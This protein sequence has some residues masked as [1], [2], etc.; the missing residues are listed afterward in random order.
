MKADQKA[1]VNFPAIKS[2]GQLQKTGPEKK[3]LCKMA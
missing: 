3:K 1:L 2:Q